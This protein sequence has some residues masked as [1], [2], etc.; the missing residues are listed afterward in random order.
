MSG[1][2]YGCYFKVVAVGI[3]VVV[4]YVNGYALVLWCGGG[5]IVGIGG[6]VSTNYNNGHYCLVTTVVVADSIGKYVCSTKSGVGCVGKCAVGV[7]Y[8]GAISGLCEAINCKVVAI[9]F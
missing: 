2:H 5:V 4:G 6:C 3:A 7:Q 1:G 9:G 8:Y